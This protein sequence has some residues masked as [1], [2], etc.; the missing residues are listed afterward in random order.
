MRAKGRPKGALG[1]DKSRGVNSSQRHPTHAE[2]VLAYE[3]IEAIEAD[4]DDDGAASRDVLL[5]PA[6]ATVEAAVSQQ[7]SQQQSNHPPSTA[8]AAINTTRESTTTI[9]LRRLKQG[10][11]YEPGT[12]LQRASMRYL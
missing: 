6:S 2:L 10:D 11:S 12:A 5:D 1:L 4:A 9:G 8:P 3:A 7:M